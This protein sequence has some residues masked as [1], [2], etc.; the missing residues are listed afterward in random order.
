[1]KKIIYIG[2]LEHNGS[3]I[4]DIILSNNDNC[5]G[6]GEFA[7]FYR[8]YKKDRSCRCG[9]KIN[10]CPFWSN[11]LIKDI[12]YNQ[13]NYH[14]KEKLFIEFLLDSYDII[15]SNKSKIYSK[16]WDR[17]YSKILNHTSKDILIDSSKNITR[18]I[19][20]LNHSQFEVYFI[21]LIRDPRG[22]YNSK[23]KRNSNFNLLKSHFMWYT[24][25]IMASIVNYQTDYYLRLKYE[26]LL[27]D[28]INFLEQIEKFVNINLN[29]SKTKIKNDEFLENEHRFSGNGISRKNQIMFNS[30]IINTNI[31]NDK[32]K[33]WFL[34]GFLSS[35]WG[36]E[37][38]Q[39]YLGD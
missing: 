16:N 5:V 25:N 7:S 4:T 30:G 8:D 14:S 1:M 9:K 13:M 34:G 32:N 38:N 11:V 10:N 12:N 35:L 17:L 6:L 37:K 26:D 39:N 18:A 22:Y 21:H 20:L 15:N 27:L 2:G 31:Y 28:P 23:K 36:Y 29:K 3:T 24:K 19:S 33:F